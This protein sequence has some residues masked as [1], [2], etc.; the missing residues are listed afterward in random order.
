[1]NPK[2]RAERERDGPSDCGRNSVWNPYA[3]V[4]SG[5]DF[6]GRKVSLSGEQCALLDPFRFFYDLFYGPG[7]GDFGCSVFI[8]HKLESSRRTGGAIHRLHHASGHAAR[9]LPL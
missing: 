1:M 5:P 9:G 3:K 8:S 6:G 2:V 4:K 7:Y